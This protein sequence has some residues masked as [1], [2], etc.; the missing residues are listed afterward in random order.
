MS[1]V[2]V[3]IP[4]GARPV[5]PRPERTPAAIRAA[6]AGLGPAGLAR[7]EQNC[8]VTMTRVR[9]GRSVLPA[10]RLVEHWWT[11]A[12]VARWPSPAELRE[13]ERVVAGSGDRAARS[14]ASAQIGA[15]LETAAAAAL[16]PVSASE[17]RLTG[18]AAACPG[19]DVLSGESHSEPSPD[20]PP[21][22]TPRMRLPLSCV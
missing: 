15:V 13:C 1:A 22:P 9:E 4:A 5:V 20:H 3:G 16:P 10:L 6:M 11:W 8:A 7:F 19:T 17:F 14:A 21:H 12:A 2:E 18:A